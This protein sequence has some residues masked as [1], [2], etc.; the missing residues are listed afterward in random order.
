[1]SDEAG[2][3]QPDG[4]RTPPENQRI[5][6][7]EHMYLDFETLSASAITM[8]MSS[9]AAL[10]LKGLRLLKA[11]LLE[12]DENAKTDMGKKGVIDLLSRILREGIAHGTKNLTLQQSALISHPLLFKMRLLRR[13]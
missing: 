5:S 2:Q 8:A 4:Q 10:Q 6:P 1:M 12:A 11:L 13:W 9:K 3:S 7:Q